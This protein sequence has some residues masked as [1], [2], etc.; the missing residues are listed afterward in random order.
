[1]VSGA[2]GGG[3]ST[4]EELRSSVAGA[5]A[6]EG[7]HPAPVLPSPLGPGAP[8]G[9]P[10]PSPAPGEAATSEPSSSSGTTAPRGPGSTKLHVSGM[11]DR[12]LSEAYTTGGSTGARAQ[13]GSLPEE[14]QA[15]GRVLGPLS[16][17]LPQYREGQV[18]THC[19]SMLGCM[20][21]GA[22]SSLGLQ[23]GVPPEQ[24]PEQRMRTGVLEKDAFLVFRCGLPCTDQGMRPA[25]K[26]QLERGSWLD[27]VQ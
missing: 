2:V 25:L 11:H 23:L 6:H 20:C 13:G 1:M 16:S 3:A 24:T 9:S 22:L 4:S 18:S 19:M 5:F 27:Q 12:K 14:G 21:A 7:G 15:P 8:T 17:G 26:P 10:S